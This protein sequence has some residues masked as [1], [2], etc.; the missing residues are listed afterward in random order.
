[1]ISL[2]RSILIIDDSPEDRL[3][4]QRFLQRGPDMSYICY[5]AA[6]AEGLERCRSLQPEAVMIDQELPNDDEMALLATLI[7][8]RGPR[9]AGRR[10]RRTDPPE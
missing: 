3:A 8:K 4:I 7:A 10:P 1:M 5:E 9:N 2:Q 6:T